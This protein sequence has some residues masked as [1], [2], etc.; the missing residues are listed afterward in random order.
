M[1]RCWAIIIILLNFNGFEGNRHGSSFRI[2]LLASAASTV[3]ATGILFSPI[4]PNIAITAI[5]YGQ[6]SQRPV[7]YADIVDKVK[8]AV[9]S[10]R[11]KVDASKLT[12]DE[13]LPPFGD[14]SLERFLR[15][16]RS[17]NSRGRNLMVRQGSGFFISDDGY[18]VTNSHV[19][20]IPRLRKQQPTQARPIRP[21][22]LV[23]IREP[24]SH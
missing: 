3:V 16:F 22:W 13:S 9:I 4:A 2:A 14:S 23:T 6:S 17:P 19:V 12:L 20:E 11:I 10:V 18:A 1:I 5:A 15:R 24:I 21:R 8:R 7:G